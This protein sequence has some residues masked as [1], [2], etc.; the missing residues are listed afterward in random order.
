MFLSPAFAGLRTVSC[1]NLGLTPQALCL[2]LLRRLPEFCAKLGVEVDQ[3]GASIRRVVL[4]GSKPVRMPALMAVK[5]LYFPEGVPLIQ[6]ND[7]T[8]RL[9]GSRVTLDTLVAA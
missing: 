8:I 4:V 3:R 7:G 1:C 6:H 9:S 5:R 2:R